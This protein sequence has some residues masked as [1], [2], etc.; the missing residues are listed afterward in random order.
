M[1]ELSNTTAQTLSPGQ[2]LT[3]DTVLLKSGCVESHRTNSGIVS[4]RAKCSIY[5]IHFSANI[6]GTTA[7]PVQLS[8]ELDGEPMAETTMISTVATAGDLNNVAA[9]TLVRTGCAGAY[10][11]ITVVNTGTS[12]VVVSP[13]PAF[14]IKRVA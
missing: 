13:N 4:L 14:Y 11:H 6:S 7:G 3:F 1:I 9:S 2:A 12:D 5:E 8:I 10:E